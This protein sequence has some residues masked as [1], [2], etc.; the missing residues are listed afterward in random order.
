MAQEFYCRNCGSIATPKKKVRGWFALELLLW[1]LFI[2][3]G[4]CYTLWRLTTKVRVCRMCGA[5]DIIPAD[6]PHA[7]A[8]VSRPQ[9]VVVA[10]A[11]VA[12]PMSGVQPLMSIPS[13]LGDVTE[14]PESVV[15][16]RYAW[17]I[18]LVPL[19]AAT[20]IAL[21]HNLASANDLWWGIVIAAGVGQL[22]LY[23][24]DVAANYGEQS[25][26]RFVLAFAVTPIWMAI[27]LW[28]RGTEFKTTRAPLWAYLGSALVLSPL[29]QSPMVSE[30]LARGFARPAASGTQILSGK[31]PLPTAAVPAAASGH[32]VEPAT[33]KAAAAVEQA[34]STVA[35]PESVLIPQSATPD[36]AAM[37]AAPPPVRV[38][39]NIKQ[40]LKVKDVTPVYPALAQAAHVQ[41]VVIV[42]A[43]IGPNG[44]VQKATVLRS[45][46]LLDAAALDAVRQWEF[47]PTLLNGVAVPVIM[48]ITVNF[49]LQ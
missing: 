40:P 19:V 31:S 14:T 7:I 46:P 8:A 44:A 45:I 5:A 1:L 49:T 25:A 11:D 18:V 4:V 17:S 43:T 38:G 34:S 3:P 39:G 10:S 35:A 22:L 33:A 20:G 23:M 21:S 47:A 12:G 28:K 48:T 29:I 36:A 41:G 26:L 16:Q 15:K 30:P 13:S 24:A 6:S 2:I 27:W 37:S 42:E 9:V 32:P